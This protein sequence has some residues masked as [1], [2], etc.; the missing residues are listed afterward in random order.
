MPDLV[1]LRTAERLLHR[2][3]AEQSERRLPSIVAGVVRDAQLVW[4]GARGLVGETAPTTDT[5]YRLG[6]ITKTLIA[7]CV[8]R[9]RDEGALELSDRISQY[10]PE[11]KAADATIA[12]LLSHSAGLQAE[13]N[14]PWWERTAGG[15]W[16]NLAG[17]L[18]GD[19]RR[20]RPGSKFHYSNVG[21]AV[22]G[23]L[24]TALRGRPWEQ[25]VH[26]EL[27]EP[28]GM[29][30]TT[31]RP[32]AP[33]AHGFAVHPWA[34]VLL[35]EPEHDAG[36]MAPAGQL[37]STLDDLAR[38]AAFLAGDTADLLSADT[39][40]EMKAPQIVDDPRDDPWR[41]GVGLGLQLWNVDGR[42]YCGHGG[43]MPG[44]LAGVR[45]DVA[46]GDAVVVLTNSTSNLT[47]ALT[48]D[49]AEIVET[50]EPRLPG[51]WVPATVPQDVLDIVGPWY[52]GPAPLVLRAKPDRWVEIGPMEGAGRASRFRPEDDGTWTGLDGYYAGETLRVVRHTDRSVSHLDVASFCLTRTPYDP[53]A[54][55]PGGVDPDGWRA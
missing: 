45:V 50:E 54:D 46:S 8:M 43:S 37:W 40:A 42:R 6:S 41:A 21:F 26:I 35:L 31:T 33:H 18:D 49:L 10:L 47:L 38:W 24:V 2:L 12:E 15:N 30:R 44:F 19:A 23:Q 22:L 7:V 14:G 17:L 4:H 11:V 13:T 20:H 55:V 29:R 1:R 27:L 28:L 34:D 3:A 16:D 51:E 36:A 25:V 52:W 39:L 9:L 48:V 32:V 5:Q 53:N